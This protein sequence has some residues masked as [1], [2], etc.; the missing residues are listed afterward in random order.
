VWNLI[1]PNNIGFTD[2]NGELWWSA[3][4]PVYVGEYYSEVTVAGE[5]SNRVVYWASSLLANS[6]R[7]GA[8]LVGASLP[9]SSAVGLQAGSRERMTALRC[10]PR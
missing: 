3:H 1:Y 4:A 10:V 8:D 9:P 5:T 7:Q 6:V 2:S